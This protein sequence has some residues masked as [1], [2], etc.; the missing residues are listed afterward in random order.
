M[1]GRIKALLA[2]L[3]VLGI[4]AMNGYWPWGP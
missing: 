2:T 3:A 1:S 4:A